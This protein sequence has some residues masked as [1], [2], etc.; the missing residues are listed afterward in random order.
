MSRES[1]KPLRGS[2]TT[3]PRAIMQK[4]LDRYRA[5]PTDANLNAVL[6]YNRKHPFA[7][8]L[9]SPADQSLLIQLEQQA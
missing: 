2:Y 6:A 5:N 4:L 1:A 7:E 3:N 8:C 9:L